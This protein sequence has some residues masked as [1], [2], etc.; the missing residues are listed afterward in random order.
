MASELKI[1][2]SFL[3]LKKLEINTFSSGQ[4]LPDCVE[5]QQDVPAAFHLA[6]ITRNVS[7]K[8]SIIADEPEVCRLKRKCVLQM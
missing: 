6:S 2:R 5:T 8:L 7:F 3:C 1:M 4:V